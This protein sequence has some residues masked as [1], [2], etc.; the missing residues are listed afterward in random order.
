MTID[1]KEN[2]I[3][4]IGGKTQLFDKE[5]VKK[6]MLA[7][8]IEESTPK[9]A[10]Y[11]KDNV[12]PIVEAVKEE[13]YNR[14]QRGWEKYGKRLTRTDV[15]F[16]EWLKHAREE[17]EDF[18]LYLMRIEHYLETQEEELQSLIKQYTNDQELGRAIRAKYSL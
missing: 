16:K 9:C 5:S 7:Y 6:A 2:L 4:N 8:K 12:D 13:I 14:S 18:S 1:N 11:E 3:I 15:S 17:A 10:N